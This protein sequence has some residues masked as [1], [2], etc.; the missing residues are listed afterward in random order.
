MV[1]GLGQTSAQD[2]ALYSH[3]MFSELELEEYGSSLTLYKEAYTEPTIYKCIEFT[4]KAHFSN[5]VHT[6]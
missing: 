2:T 4:F 3:D 5:A 1:V 6:G